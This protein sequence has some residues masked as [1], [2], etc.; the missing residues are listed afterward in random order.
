MPIAVSAY[1]RLA[2][3]ILEVYERAETHMLGRVAARMKKGV[4]EPG[5][6]E[7][8][9][10]EITTVRK[11]LSSLV[12]GLSEKRKQMSAQ[13]IADAYAES[14]EAFVTEARSFEEW[15]DA[16]N[17]SQNAVKVASILS[18][19]DESLDAA[20]R[21]ILRQVND[22]YA[23]VVG[24]A[25]SLAATG[26]ITVR[27]A[28]TD[29]LK[30]FADRGITSFVDKAG[31]HWDMSTYAEMATLTALER[32]TI[33]GYT[34]TMQ[35]YGFDLAVI[36]DHVG[37]CPLCAAWQGVIIS[38]SGN[39]SK[40][41]SLADAEASGVFHPRCLHHLSTYYEGIT[42]N[43]RNKPRD[44]EPPSSSYSVRSIQRRYEVAIRRWKRRMAVSTNPQDERIAYAHVRDYQARIR[45]LLSSYN[46][47]TDKSHDWLPRKYWRE[48]GEIRLSA[49]AKKLPPVKLK[50]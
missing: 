43:T 38:V 49:A 21:M 7:K 42:K 37:A 23:D 18:E 35:A 10:A 9:Y 13:F 47:A 24:R 26:T 40:Y 46:S 1:E 30:R 14:A 15:A 16:I 5:W 31:R 11:E 12:S 41:P 25:T 8:K 28:V 22:V 34:D 2:A 17:F 29:E 32:A 39:D 36:S 33:E 44:V 4:D 45:G 3:E 20:D 27:D 50:E 48:G 6:T 19:L